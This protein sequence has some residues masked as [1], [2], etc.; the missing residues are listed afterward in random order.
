MGRPALLEEEKR[1]VQVN[2]RLTKEE[3]DIV[4]NY[5]E[6]SGLSPANWIRQKA[7]TG[8][9]PVIKLSP[10][11]ASLYRELQKIGINLNQAVKQLHAGKLSPAY[12]TILTALM[13]TQ[14]EILK[15]L[16]K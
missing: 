9:F 14:Q 15:D 8:K 13:K 12:L 10:I 4:C 1:L 3:N 7:F 16:I 6:A 11:N 2:I 5:A